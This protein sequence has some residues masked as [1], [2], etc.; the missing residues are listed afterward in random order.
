MQAGQFAQ[1]VQVPHPGKP[2]RRVVALARGLLGPLIRLCFR[3][4]WTGVEHLPGQGPY[5]LV[6]NHSAGMG[7]AELLSFVALWLAQPGPPR[8]LAGFALPVGFV[9]WPLSMLHRWL[10]TVPSTYHHAKQALGQGVPLL[11]FPGGD[12]ESL[13]PVWRANQVDFGGRV[14]FLRIAQTAGVPIVPLGIAGAAWSAP[15]LFRSHWLATLLIV[16]RLIGV[17]RWGLSLLGVAV[18]AVLLTLLP[19]ALPIRLFVV[20]LWLGSPLV[21]LPMFPVTV[22]FAVGPSLPPEGL[23]GPAGTSTAGPVAEPEGQLQTALHVVEQAVQAQVYRAAHSRR[24][25]GG[26]AAAAATQGRDC[27]R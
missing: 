1:N 26:A 13:Q 24:G 4:T 2:N 21:F 10:G 8:P 12:H 14:G 17:K 6:A 22:R 27:A 25:V 16:P 5:L 9:V 15:I 3:P 23:F 20:W 19:W 7:I 11:V 18:A